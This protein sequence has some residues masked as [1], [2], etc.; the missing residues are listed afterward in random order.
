MS[1][2]EHDLGGQVLD[3]APYESMVKG[4][5]AQRDVVRA[6][7]RCLGIVERSTSHERQATRASSEGW[8]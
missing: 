3:D 2:A 7:A 1:V 5:E 8:W 6:C 4:R